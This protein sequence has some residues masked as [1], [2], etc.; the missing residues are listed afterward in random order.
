MAMP[1]HSLRDGLSPRKAKANTADISAQKNHT[2]DE[3]IMHPLT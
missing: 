3:F 1:V 2:P